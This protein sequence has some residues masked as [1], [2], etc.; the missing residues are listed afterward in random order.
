MDITIRIMIIMILPKPD[1]CA[2][3]CKTIISAV[4]KPLNSL[5]GNGTQKYSIIFEYC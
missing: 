1:G 5:V 3:D 2:R 4:S